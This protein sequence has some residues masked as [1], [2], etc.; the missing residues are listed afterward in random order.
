MTKSCGGL[1]TRSASLSAEAARRPVSSE[2]PLRLDVFRHPLFTETPDAIFD[3]ID[4]GFRTKPALGLKELGYLSVAHRGWELKHAPIP[5]LDAVLLESPGFCDIRAGFFLGTNDVAHPDSQCC[6]F[7]WT[8]RLVT[9][10]KGFNNGFF[11]ATHLRLFSAGFS[12]NFNAS[13]GAA[14]EGLRQASDPIP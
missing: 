8:C 14:V 13:E 12:L 1:Q 4:G 6:L 2:L 3:A 9:A 10:G 11:C 5:C 7:V